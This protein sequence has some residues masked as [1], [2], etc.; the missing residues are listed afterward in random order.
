MD[1]RINSVIS[2][3]RKWLIP[4]VYFSE[5]KLTPKPASLRNLSTQ[6]KTVLQRETKSNWR[7]V[8]LIGA[9][10]AYNGKETVFRSDGTLG[11]YNLAVG[12]QALRERLFPEDKKL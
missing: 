12:H 3:C 9:R 4:L 10:L 11:G 8:V 6:H 1:N 5:L 7:T 2:D